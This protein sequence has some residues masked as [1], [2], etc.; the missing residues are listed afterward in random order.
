MDRRKKNHLGKTY[1]SG[2]MMGVKDNNGIEFVI[3]SRVMIRYNPEG[4]S[5]N[6]NGLYFYN[7]KELKDYLREKEIKG[8][9]IEVVT[10]YERAPFIPNCG[11]YKFKGHPDMIKGT[12]KV[13]EAGSDKKSRNKLEKILKTVIK[14]LKN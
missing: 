2:E 4:I 7:T 6:N 1:M 13:G 3:G 9:S 5:S 12:I 8:G 11:T 10:F 14:R